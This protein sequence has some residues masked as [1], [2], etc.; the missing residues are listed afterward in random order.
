MKTVVFIHAARAND[1][2][3]GSG[4]ADDP[5]PQICPGIPRA[6][7]LGHEATEQTDPEEEH[8][9]IQNVVD[10]AQRQ[11]DGIVSQHILEIEV[12]IQQAVQQDRRS[13]ADD[14]AVEL[15]ATVFDPG[16]KQ[17]NETDLKENDK[18]GCDVR[19]KADIHIRII[20]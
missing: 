16:N 10:D 1:T 18:S 17:H 15:G 12:E 2:D 20:Q 11:P 19:D 9:C 13:E 6:G 8:R 7:W 5:G 3:S 14:H 4:N